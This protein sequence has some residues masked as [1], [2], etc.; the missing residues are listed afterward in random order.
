MTAKRIWIHL[1]RLAAIGL[2]VSA[3]MASEFHG[4]V[5]CGGLPFPGVTVTAAQNDQKVVTTTDAQGV[6]RYPEL[7]DGVWTIEVEMLGFEK[8]TRQVGV[9][10]RKSV[11]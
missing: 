4:T 9:A 5:K 6:F 10:D 8:I 2:S 11:V 7:A 1:S 3:L